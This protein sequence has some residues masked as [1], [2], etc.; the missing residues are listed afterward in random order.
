MVGEALESQEGRL[1]PDARLETRTARCRLRHRPHAVL[2]NSYNRG[3]TWYIPD[4]YFVLLIYSMSYFFT[5]ISQF[6]EVPQ[7]S[8]QECLNE[9]SDKWL[10]VKEY[11]K[12][13]DNEHVHIIFKSDRFGRTDKYTEFIRNKCFDNKFLLNLPLTHKL[14][15]TKNCKDWKKIYKGYLLKESHNKVHF[16]SLSYKGFDEVEL[17]RIYKDANVNGLI[18]SLTRV[19][20]S[21]APYFCYDFY[22][23]NMS[24]RV[25]QFKWFQEGI[26]DEILLANCRDYVIHHLLDDKSINKIYRVFRELISASKIYANAS[27][28]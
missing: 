28:N 24:T 4:F 18:R 23:S 9:L 12:N 15:V 7:D 1:C 5:T 11:G 8:L 26:I 27:K 13:Q 22:C 3:N 6:K 2:P 16:D 10:F 17:K 20:F 25:W 19:S 14:V 21:Q